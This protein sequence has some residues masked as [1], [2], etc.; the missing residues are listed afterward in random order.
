MRLVFGHAAE[1]IGQP[2]A[3]G[4]DGQHL[5]KVGER[6]GIFKRMRGVGVGVA[7]AVGAEHFDGDLRRHRA[8]RDGLRLHGLIHHDGHVG[9]DRLAFR[10]ELRHIHHH[11]HAVG[12]QRLAFGIQLGRLHRDR[13]IRGHRLAF[14]VGF[15]HLDGVRFQ[16]L[17]L[18][19]GLEIL[20]HALRHQHDRKHQADRQQQIISDAHQVHPEIAEQLGRMPRDAAHQRRG[21]GDAGGRRAEVVNHQRDHLREI[22]HGGFAAVALPVGV[23]RE[24]DGGVERQ[25]RRQRAKALRIERQKI[26]QPQNRISEHAAHQAEQQHGPGVLPPVLLLLRRARP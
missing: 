16:E 19:V 26:L 3:D 18:G 4:E 14:G 6:R 1:V 12:H 5:E 25:I 9:H 15:L 22:G 10:I 13:H 7:A 20:N 21:D 8:L 17:R 23:R 24:A 2:A 11:R